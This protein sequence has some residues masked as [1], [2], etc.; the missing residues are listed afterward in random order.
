MPFY[1]FFL[2]WEG[3]P[4]KIDYRKR[5][6]VPTS[7]NLSTGDLDNLWLWVAL[8]RGSRKEPASWHGCL[9]SRSGFPTW[10]ELPSPV[11]HC[12]SSWAWVPRL[13][14]P[15]FGGRLQVA[16]T[17]GV[18]QSARWEASFLFP[19]GWLDIPMST[20]GTPSGGGGGGERLI[21]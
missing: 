20:K 4:T 2:G 16:W 8:E 1:R 18:G 6:R 14:K 5:H 9:A 3:S 10:F 17:E 7:S 21:V 19:Q 12:L 11:F 13:G 15:L